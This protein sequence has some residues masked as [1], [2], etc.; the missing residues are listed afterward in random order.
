MRAR[1]DDKG[2]LGSARVSFHVR[3]SLASNVSRREK[4]LHESLSRAIA[5]MAEAIQEYLSSG[6]VPSLLTVLF[7]MHL[8]APCCWRTEERGW[9]LIIRQPLRHTLLY[10]STISTPSRQKDVCLVRPQNS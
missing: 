8:N 1:A 4:E 5:T 3:S 7:K 6:T 2:V 10:L 9:K